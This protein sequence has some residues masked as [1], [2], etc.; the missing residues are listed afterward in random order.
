MFLIVAR[1]VKRLDSILRSHVYTHFG[2]TLSGLMTVRA[3]GKQEE[4]SGITDQNLD[5]MNRA[6]FVTIINQRWLGIRLNFVGNVLIFIV[7]ILVVT[8]RFQVS[9]S[10]SGMI[11]AYC[12]QIVGNMGQLTKQYAEVQN[13]MNATER[14]HHYATAIENEAPLEILDRKPIITW[15]QEGE[16]IVKDAVMRYRSDLPPVLKGLSLRI[17][18]GERIGIGDI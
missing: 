7:S 16:I 15:P 2:E 12:V 6:Y 9:P 13:N 10:I 14:V 1:E 8:S 18:G 3:F 17:L 4:F 11:L 5:V